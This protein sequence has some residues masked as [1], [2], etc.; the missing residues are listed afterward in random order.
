MTYLGRVIYDTVLQCNRVVIHDRV[1]FVVNDGPGTTRLTP[2]GGEACFNSTR[3]LLSSPDYPRSLSYCFSYRCLLSVR[4]DDQGSNIV[5]R[6]RSSRICCKHAF[7]ESVAEIGNY[8]RQ[9]KTCHGKVTDKRKHEHNA[10]HI[11]EPIQAKTSL[12][13]PRRIARLRCWIVPQRPIFAGRA[14]YCEQRAGERRGIACASTS[15]PPL[16]LS[17]SRLLI[18]RYNVGGFRAVLIAPPR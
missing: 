2:R 18:A 13:S 17:V 9:K 12:V 10:A 15:L 4:R 5:E 11:P 6:I 8:F 16:F 7:T 1:S 14:R 3:C